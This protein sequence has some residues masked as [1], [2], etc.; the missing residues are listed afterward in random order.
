[1]GNRQFKEEMVAE[2]KGKLEKSSA[3]VLT[4]YRGLT[5]AEATDLRRQLRAEGIEFKVLKNTLIR[6]AA[7]ELGYDELE[8]FLQGPTAIAFGYEDPALPANIIFKFAKS[9]DKLEI[10]AGMLSG[11]VIL[12]ADVHNLASLPSKEVLL[13]QVL[14]VFQSPLA[15]I[16]SVLQANLRSFVNVLDA[17]LEVKSMP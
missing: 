2:I 16:T 6:R 8:P 3:L 14:S 13:S 1:M 4:D 15:G 10:K 9:S 11:E 12:A 7:N 5:V 17:Y